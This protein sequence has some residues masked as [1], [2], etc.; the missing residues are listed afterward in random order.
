MYAVNRWLPPSV[1]FSCV[2]PSV[3]FL[4]SVAQVLM[5]LLKQFKNNFF[6]PTW[7]CAAGFN[8]NNNI[9][10]PPLFILI[11]VEC[12]RDLAVLSLMNNS[13]HN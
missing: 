9:I 11:P 8:N 1:V 13:L 2:C 6:F 12:C 4:F 3:V 5:G 7:T 10:N